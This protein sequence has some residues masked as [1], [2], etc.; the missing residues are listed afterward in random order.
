MAMHTVKIIKGGR[1]LLRKQVSEGLGRDAVV[2]PAQA[3]VTYLF[4]DPLNNAGPAKMALQAHKVPRPQA[5]PR[6]T[7]EI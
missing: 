3:D 2:S 1:T 6:R 7:Q 5:Y 4:S